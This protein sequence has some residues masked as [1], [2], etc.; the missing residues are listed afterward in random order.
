MSQHTDLGF[1]HLLLCLSPMPGLHSTTPAAAIVLTDRID[2]HSF[3]HPLLNTVPL[4]GEEHKNEE[5]F[6]LGKLCCLFSL[7]FSKWALAENSLEMLIPET[8]FLGEI[9]FYCHAFL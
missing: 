7:T 3:V 4:S 2:I 6:T 9:S 5:V 1:F 8:S